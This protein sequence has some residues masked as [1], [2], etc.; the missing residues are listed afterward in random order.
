MLVSAP[1]AAQS[2][3][4]YRPVPPGGAAYA[5]ALPSL[6]PDGQWQTINS[7][8]DA[9]GTLWHLR[10]AWNVAALYCI[11]PAEAP[12]LTGYRRFLSAY[13]QPL[14]AANA[15]LDRRFRASAVSAN[16]AIRAREAQM[17]QLYNYLAQPP[18]RTEY[19]AAA[20]GLANEFLAG[21]P[22][23]ASAF[24]T[25]G[26][27]RFEAVFQDFYRRYAQYRTDSAAWDAEWGALYG[28]TQPGWVAVHGGLGPSPLPASDTAPPA[29]PSI[30]IGERG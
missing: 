17:T 23:D 30:V 1:A 13:A 19:C 24:A 21:P 11:D 8:L 29:V 4:P 6:G 5:M 18:V 10:S 9:A 15:A 16:A 3:V 25:T 26:L 28:S 12:I 20:L 2:S 22:V 27:P 7:G 14:A